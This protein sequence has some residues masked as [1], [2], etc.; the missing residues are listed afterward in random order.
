[1]SLAENDRSVK[2]LVADT[3]KFV[4]SQENAEYNMTDKSS[5]GISFDTTTNIIQTEFTPTDFPSEV[6]SPANVSNMAPLFSDE[7]ATTQPMVCKS[8]YSTYEDGSSASDSDSVD[9]LKRDTW[10]NKIDFLL[11]CI[12]F[13]VGLGNVW[14]FPYLCYKNG[15]G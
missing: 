13:S 7:K 15:G 11:A 8:T 6:I 9:Q 12:G 2:D 3:K 5:E 14:R 4:K 1:M 10:N